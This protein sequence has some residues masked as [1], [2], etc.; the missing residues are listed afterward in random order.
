M[1]EK[2]LGVICEDKFALGLLAS[3]GILRF[4]TWEEKQ[5]IRTKIRTERYSTHHKDKKLYL[6][7]NY[8]NHDRQ[9]TRAVGKVKRALMEKNPERQDVVAMK[10]KGE[11]W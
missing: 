11:V 3:A 8:S 9:K 2:D 7:D 6:D 10:N 4:R 1:I 5:A